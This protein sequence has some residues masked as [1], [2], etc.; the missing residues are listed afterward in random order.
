M[1]VRNDL[2]DRA[3]LSDIELRELNTSLVIASAG[4][5][6]VMIEQIPFAVDLYDGVVS[7]PSDYRFHKSSLISERS[8]R[9]IT[10][11][12]AEIMGRTC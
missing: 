1:I 11:S 2:L 7:R 4:K 5:L 6:R 12:I 9:I 8:L 10:F 3:V